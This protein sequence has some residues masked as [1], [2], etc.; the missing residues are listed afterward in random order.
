MLRRGVAPSATGDD[1]WCDL[2]DLDMVDTLLQTTRAPGFRLVRDGRV[3]PRAA[4]TRTGTVGG[5]RVTDLPDV[6]AIHEQFRAGATVVLQGLNRSHPPIARLCRG[7]ERILTYPVQAN[8]YLTPPSAAGLDVHHDTHDV[9][10]LQLHGTKRWTTWT[11]AVRDPLPGQ[12]WRGEVDA[13]GEP[14]IDT[15]LRPGDLLYLPR[16][17]LHA[18]RTPAS[19]SLH[20][21]IGLRAPTAH[22]LLR[23]LLRRARDEPAFRV[24]LP[25]GYARDPAASTAWA[26]GVLEELATWTSDLDAA[27]LAEDLVDGFHSSRPPLLDGQLRQLLGL[28]RIDDHTRVTRRPGVTALLRPA[29]TRV[30]LRLGDRTVSLPGFVATAVERLLSADGLMVSSLHDVL[31]DGNSRVVLVRRLVRE[32]LLVADDPARR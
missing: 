15:D 12:G 20:L 22:D 5:V 11:P 31:G 25:P 3:L 29:G 30:E 8:A 10:A 27:A 19:P 6:G 4:S 23:Q 16:G 9:L 26:A 32:G 14:T 1:G 13:L 7:L 18:A 17:T 21:T 28:D 2:L 24:A